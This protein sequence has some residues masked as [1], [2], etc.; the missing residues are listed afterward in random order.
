MVI[1]GLKGK[2][3]FLDSAP[4][5]YF[6]DGHSVYQS[7]LAELFKAN[8]AGKVMFI[9]STITLLEVLVL[10]MRSGREDIAGQYQKLLT[11]SNNIEIIELTK[12]V[13]ITAA[14]LRAKY[15]LKTP[16]SIQLATAIEYKTD[17]FL[18]ND[19]KLKNIERA[20]V[21]TLQDLHH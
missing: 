2:T 7:I 8:D 15:N 9:T 1:S 10:P 20:N 18:T 13:A 12:S 6:I 19:L 17:F 3:L 14:R 5:I 4:L 11:E 16:D 21:L